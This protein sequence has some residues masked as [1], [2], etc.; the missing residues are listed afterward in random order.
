MC[1]K[2]SQTSCH[3][4]IFK[5]LTAIDTWI[6]FLWHSTL[7]QNPA[8]ISSETVWNNKLC[9]GLLWQPICR[10]TLWCL[11]ISKKW[12][13]IFFFFLISLVVFILV[14]VSRKNM[15][16]S[17]QLHK[18]NW[19]KFWVHQPEPVFLSGKSWYGKVLTYC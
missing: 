7:W 15:V 11:K 8:K 17:L 12:S 2:S 3:E 19:S 9:L 13:A 18:D 6:P 1:N 5:F 16:V 4:D 14:F 10:I